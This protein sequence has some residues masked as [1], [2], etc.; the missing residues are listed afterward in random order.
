MLAVAI[1]FRIAYP[2]AV[3]KCQV[4]FL[5]L[6]LNVNTDLRSRKI[7]LS[8]KEDVKAKL[9]V[10]ETQG[11]IEKVDSP[12]PWI[13]HLQPVRSSLNKCVSVLHHNCSVWAHH[14]TCAKP[15]CLR[16]VIM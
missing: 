13:S 16:S 4:N 8:M 9:D 7:A 3:T 1:S 2:L 5:L 11:V 15:N 14:K 12:T 10:L 6:T